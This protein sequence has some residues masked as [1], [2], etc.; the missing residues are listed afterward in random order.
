MKSTG[1]RIQLRR[2]ELGWSREYLAER[3]EMTRMSVWRIEAG[4][5]Q[6]KADSLRKF[7]RILRTSVADLLA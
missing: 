5:T 6:V 4:K 7:A 3:L 2:E 1:N